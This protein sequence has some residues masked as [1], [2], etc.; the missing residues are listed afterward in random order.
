MWRK[1]ERETQLN[2]ETTEEWRLNTRTVHDTRPHEHK[3]LYIGALSQLVSSLARSSE[4]RTIQKWLATCTTSKCNVLSFCGSRLL[5]CC[6]VCSSLRA[7]G[8]PLWVQVRSSAAPSI[9]L[10]IVLWCRLGPWCWYVNSWWWKMPGVGEVLGTTHYNS[11]MQKCIFEHTTC[12]TS[13]WYSSRR[14]SQRN[15]ANKYLIKCSLSV[16]WISYREAL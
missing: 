4:K 9:T 2:P 5:L 16:C 6:V 13:K 14:P 7:A 1:A 11:G 12:Q 10:Q 8:S 15:K 3:T